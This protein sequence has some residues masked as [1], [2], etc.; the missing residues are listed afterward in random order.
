M[1]IL[2]KEKDPALDRCL[3]YPAVQLPILLTLGGLTLDGGGT[4]G[5]ILGAIFVYSIGLFIIV[6]RRSRRLTLVDKILIRWGFLLLCLVFGF[7]SAL[8]TWHL[9][10]L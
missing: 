2:A 1:A 3:I 9:K 6:A 5:I 7:V 10:G 8:W 4:L